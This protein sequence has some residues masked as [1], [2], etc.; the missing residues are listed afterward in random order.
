MW[1]WLIALAIVT[2]I[3]V[4]PL[5]VSARYDGLGAQVAV[6]AGPVRF[7]VYPAKKKEKAPNKEKKTKRPSKDVSDTKNKPDTSSGGSSGASAPKESEGG[8]VTDFLPLVDHVLEF[9]K[10]LKRKLRV[11]RLELKLILAGDDPCDLAVNYGKTWAAV[12]GLFPILEQHLVIKKRDVEVECDF[13]SDETKVSAR[14]DI[15]ITVGRILCLGI[16]RGVPALL[17]Y[18]KIMKTRK[19]GA[20]K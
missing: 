7:R 9:L 10:R 3:A 20:V 2:L 11:D 4:F 12:G 13:T 17:A 16:G 19:G 1:G 6:I 5:G 14:V 8:S 18:M 15:T